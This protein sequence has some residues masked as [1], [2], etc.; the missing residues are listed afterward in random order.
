[1][2]QAIVFLD[3]DGVLVNNFKHD[4]RIILEYQS[5]GVNHRVNYAILDKECVGWLNKITQEANAKLCLSSTWRI[6]P[7]EE[8]EL[9]KRYLKSEGVEADF[10]GRTPSAHE[11]G[12]WGIRGIE[13]QDWLDRNPTSKFVIIDD[14]S[15]MEHL[16]PRLVRTQPD[17][18]LT[19]TEADI[20]IEMLNE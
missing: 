16:T 19:K 2:Y 4:N 11:C 12:S 9:T 3:I 5:E 6:G 17:V 8:F 20:A 13:I 14:S 10:V 15:D 1:M 7:P 18:G